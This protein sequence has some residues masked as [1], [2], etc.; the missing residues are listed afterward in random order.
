MGWIQPYSHVFILGSSLN[1]SGNIN[2]GHD[3]KGYWYF[4]SASNGQYQLYDK[5]GQN[6]YLNYGY[7]WANQ[8][9]SRFAVSSN[10]RTVRLFKESD[11][12]ARLTGALLQ[13]VSDTDNVTIEELLRNVTIQ[14]SSNGTDVTGTDTVTADML[15]WYTDF[16]ATLAGTYTANV[17]Y[18]EVI[19]GS[20]T[21]TVTT[22][23]C[24]EATVVDPTCT[25][26]GYTEVTCTDCGVTHRYDYTNPMGHSYTYADSGNQRIYTCVRCGESY[27]ESLTLSCRQV[28]TFTSGNR[29]V[30]A[31]KSGG[32]YY[33]M[34]HGG[35]C[36]R[37]V[38]ISVI[39]GEI[40]TGVTDDLLWNYHSGKLSYVKD[41]TTFYLNL[42]TSGWWYWN[43]TD[44]GISTRNA[45]AVS[46][47]NNKLQIGSLYL[48]YS[49]STFSVD[50]A[51]T[52]AYI[53]KA[54]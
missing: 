53:F 50:S 16:D 39:N 18:Q 33:A 11:T 14:L 29:F 38:Q 1:V 41:G 32:K 20:I 19:V 48:R 42:F 26:F 45:A 6:W 49:N 4:G 17:F 13:T 47:H 15:D 3:S 52:A 10:A 23:H 27:S 12:Y 24:Y 2:Y 36:I 54:P 5:D 35:N 46:F 7:V 9:V 28:S 25:E 40:T 37:P 44:I 21:I 22:N 34:S 30:I 51:Y 31:I 43:I 8:S